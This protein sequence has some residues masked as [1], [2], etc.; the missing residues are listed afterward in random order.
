[1]IDAVRWK[2][3]V[4][5]ERREDSLKKGCGDGVKFFSFSLNVISLGSFF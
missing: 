5:G 4:K 3:V 1:M 2:V